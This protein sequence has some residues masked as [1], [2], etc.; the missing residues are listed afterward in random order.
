MENSKECKET[1][2]T[3]IGIIV[4]VVFVIANVIVIFK[5]GSENKIF[6]TSIKIISLLTAIFY[7]I[8]IIPITFSVLKIKEIKKCYYYILPFVYAFFPVLLL[9]QNDS[10]NISCIAFATFLSSLGMAFC[11]YRIFNQA[12]KVDIKYLKFARFVVST[13]LGIVCTFFEL[14]CSNIDIKLLVFC[15]S[16]L[17]LLEIVYK[18]LDL[19][20]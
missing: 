2:K 17:L 19:E 13:F 3:I 9:F 14:F 11:I 16:L 20:R 18:K 7:C 1:S 12:E 10:Q 5:F 8:A 15:A 4:M 6:F